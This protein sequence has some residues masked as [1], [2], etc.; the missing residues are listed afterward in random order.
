MA[1]DLPLEVDAGSLL[2]MGLREAKNRNI[3][4][5]VQFISKAGLIMNVLFL[6]HSLPLIR[7]KAP[8]NAHSSSS[9][10]GPRI[11]HGRELAG[12]QEQMLLVVGRVW[13]ST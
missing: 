5:A 13:E 3:E 10:S 9:L 6:D 11:E 7:Y 4:S 12:G 8:L 2:A 1:L